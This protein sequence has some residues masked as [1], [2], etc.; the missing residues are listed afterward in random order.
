MNKPPISR[1][2]PGHPGETGRSVQ[3]AISLLSKYQGEIRQTETVEVVAECL[4]S[5]GMTDALV[6]QIHRDWLSA[7]DDRSL[8]RRILLAKPLVVPVKGLAD[9]LLASEAQVQTLLTS[10]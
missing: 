3:E 2:T 8:A 6:A 1:T 10:I 5:L 4:V 7:S 9:K